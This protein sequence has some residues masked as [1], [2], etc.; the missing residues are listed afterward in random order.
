MRKRIFGLM[1][2][3]CMLGLFTACSDDDPQPVPEPEP[4]PTPVVPGENLVEK[5]YPTETVEVKIGDETLSGKVAKFTPKEDGTAELTL[6]GATVN[7]TDL[8]PADTESEPKSRG[9]EESETIGTPGVIPGSPSV[10][11]SLTL[12]GDA[13]SCSFSGTHETEYCTFGYK[14]SVNAENVNLNI[15]DLKLKNTSLVGTYNIVEN[16]KTNAEGRA[17]Y[18]VESVLRF[19][20]ESNQWLFCFSENY[21]TNR[22]EEWVYNV[23]MQDYFTGYGDK[24]TVADM[25]GLKYK[26]ITL[27]EAGDFIL[28]LGSDNKTD[29]GNEIKMQYVMKDDNTILLFAEPGLLVNELMPGTG[30]DKSCFNTIFEPIVNA[31]LPM[32][33]KGIP[34]SYG[35]ALLFARKYTDSWPAG[36]AIFHP[37]TTPGHVSF[38]LNTETLRPLLSIYS[39]TLRDE[40]SRS[41][42]VSAFAGINNDAYQK[43]MY[44]TWTTPFV[45]R[46]LPDV[47]DNTKSVEIGLNF[48][49]E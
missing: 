6:E 42:I 34:V 44:G 17:A 49:K 10:T 3:V 27:T 23:F 2:A 48:M 46:S 5:E 19:A 15:S 35:P 8:Y 11:L 13:S 12:E 24:T 32:C 4:T 26:S 21:G 39:A 40:A 1:A 9:E 14:G 7:I 18:P 38:Y 45:L 37:T 31:M 41:R 36:H 28:T 30:N 22:I 16:V 29:N 25:I 33:S 20:W 47:I 43:S